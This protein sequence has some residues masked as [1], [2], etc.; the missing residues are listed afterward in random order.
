MEGTAEDESTCGMISFSARHLF[1]VVKE[2]NGKG[3]VCDIAASFL[4]IHNEDLHDLLS[5]DSENDKKLEIKHDKKLRK[6]WVANITS[7]QLDNHEHVTRLIKHTSEN[8]SSERSAQ[9]HRIFQF[10]VVGK[11][12]NNRKSIEGHLSLINL[13]GSERDNCTKETSK[14]DAVSINSNLVCL[15]N[16]IT[17]LANHENNVPFH[18]SKLTYLLQ[19]SL[20]GNAK[21]L[22]FATVSP[23]EEDL[24]ESLKYVILF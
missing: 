20:G 10:H 13:A 19:N 1:K 12:S 21:A 2:M 14:K 6:T 18:S 3:W 9:S 7:V 23:C 24:K 16:V 15:S 11:N 8:R 17:A 4:E 5:K 22:M